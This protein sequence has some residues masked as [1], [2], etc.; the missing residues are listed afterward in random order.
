MY[1]FIFIVL[2]ILFI[3]LILPT[4]VKISFYYDSNATDFHFKIS[5]LFGLLK[6]NYKSS[7]TDVLE[8]IVSKYSNK[9]DN[10][11]FMVRNSYIFPKI[12]EFFFKH[13]KIHETR[14]RIGIGLDDAFITAIIISFIS[15][16]SG[17]FFSYLN[18]KMLFSMA[19]MQMLPLY[20]SMRLSINGSCI[21]ETKLGNIISIIIKTLMDKRKRG[22]ES[23]GTTH[24]K[25]Y[26]NYNGK[27]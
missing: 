17:S 14:L 16:I 22:C 20:N 13:V 10:K 12:K 25:S 2:T 15:I 19:E 8:K 3:L 27:H 5:S 23:D 6:Y 1:I 21:I 18:K 9:Q 11:K 7:L 24:S 26:E 4:K